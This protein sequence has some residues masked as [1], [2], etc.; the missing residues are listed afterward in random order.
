MDFISGNI[1][2]R[3]MRFDRIGQ[4]RGGHKH[5]FDHTTYV[6]RGAIR[7]E[8]LADDGS[9][10]RAVEKRATDGRNWV[11]IRAHAAHRVIA[12]EADT[13]AHCIYSHRDPQGEVVQ[14][15]DGF[16]PAYS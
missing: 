15:W 1:F 12:L 13:V 6:V 3:E 14:A 7:V 4:D 9:V 8:H 10:L 2:V 16:T 5:N 11:L